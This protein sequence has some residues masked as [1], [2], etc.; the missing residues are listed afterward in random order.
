MIDMALNPAL[1]LN[2]KSEVADI[3]T[4]DLRGEE[5]NYPPLQSNIP[6]DPEDDLDASTAAPVHSNHQPGVFDESFLSIAPSH[7]GSAV[8]PAVPSTSGLQS[9]PTA[10][11]IIPQV[12]Q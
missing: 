7:T 10:S 8:T 4:I 1:M 3:P 11:L 2:F 12:H 6:R 5:A 9:I